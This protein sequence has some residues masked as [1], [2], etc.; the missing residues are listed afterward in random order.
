MTDD[1]PRG[2]RSVGRFDLIVRHI[3]AGEALPDG[4]VNAIFA[5]N[6]MGVVLAVARAGARLLDRLLAAIIDASTRE[7]P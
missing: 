6:D 4:L 5:E 7:R 3:G 2:D 1:D